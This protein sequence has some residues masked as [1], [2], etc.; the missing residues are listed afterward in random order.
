MYSLQLYITTYHARDGVSD[1]PE[2]SNHIYLLNSTVP[3]LLIEVG[4]SESHELPNSFWVG[5]SGSWDP[6]GVRRAQPRELFSK[7]NSLHTSRSVFHTK[8]ALPARGA[9]DL[10]L[11]SARG[12]GS[13]SHATPIATSHDGHPFCERA[14]R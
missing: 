12:A 11:E 9:L 1:T 2:Y 14:R 5:P 8:I 3:L 10:L 7:K 4:A 13:K 6:H